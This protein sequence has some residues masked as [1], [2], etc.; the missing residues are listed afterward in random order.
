MLWCISR[1]TSIIFPGDGPPLGQ[2]VLSYR[3]S[4]QLIRETLPGAE[5]VHH[6]LSIVSVDLADL[7]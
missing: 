6:S 4:R 5:A 1:D 7:V 2:I 3:F